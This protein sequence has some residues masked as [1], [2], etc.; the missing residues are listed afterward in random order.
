[1]SKIGKIPIKIPEEVRVSLGKKVTVSGP[2]GELEYNLPDGIKVKKKENELF[3]LPE[4]TDIKTKALHGT[5]RQL[6][7]NMVEGVTEGFSKTLEIVGTGYRASLEGKKL[8]LSLGFSHPVE[9]IPPEGI[10]YE[11]VDGKIKISGISKAQVGQE[12]ARIRKIRPPDA[13]KGKG[14]RYEGEEIKLKPGKA[15]KVGAGGEI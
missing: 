15:A 7:A 12:A 10:S 11:I 13:Y 5:A 3:V 6:L 2:K 9:V 4:K 8:V 14:I 1:M